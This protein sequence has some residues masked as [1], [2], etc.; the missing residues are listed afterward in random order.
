MPSVLWGSMSLPVFGSVYQVEVMLTC[1]IS[2]PVTPLIATLKHGASSS[3]IPFI[4]KFR[5]LETVSIMGR[6]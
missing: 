1:E 2:A 6:P 5:D 4:L 3:V